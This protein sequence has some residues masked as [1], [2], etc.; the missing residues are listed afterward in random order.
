MTRIPS[1]LLAA[2]LLAACS[3]GEDRSSAEPGAAPSRAQAPQAP[4]QQPAAPP[5][6]AAPGAA[7]FMLGTADTPG[8]LVGTEGTYGGPSHFGDPDSGAATPAMAGAPAGLVDAARGPVAVMEEVR[9]PPLVNAENRD[10]RRTRSYFLQPPTI[11]HKIDNYQIDRNAN[12]CMECHARIRAEESRAVPISISHYTGRD[13]NILADISPRRYFCTQCHVVQ[14][15]T[16]PLVVN[17]YEDV[18]EVLRR[19]AAQR[20]AQR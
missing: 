1:L 6:G 17:R 16:D 13:G 8:A 11:P 10:I 3:E 5:G 19:E 14:M 2:A 9:P 7:P 12:R 4:A 18:A 15:E 20:S